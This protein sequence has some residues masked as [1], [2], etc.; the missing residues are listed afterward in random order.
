LERDKVGNSPE[1][2]TEVTEAM[3]RLDRV[4]GNLYLLP[5]QFEDRFA[6]ILSQPIEK[7][8][9]EKLEKVKVPLAR[10]IGNAT[11]KLLA[12]LTRLTGILNR[13]QL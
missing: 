3:E 10:D 13:T 11:D 12:C 9:G 2:Q 7:D 8:E 1:A 5:E 4:A 6:A